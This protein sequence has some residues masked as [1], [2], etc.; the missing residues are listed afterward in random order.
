MKFVSYKLN[1]KLKNSIYLNAMSESA[2]SR[3]WRGYV[4]ACSRAWRVY[5]LTCLRACLT[6]LRA[7]RARVLSVLLYSH[8]SLTWRT[9]LALAYSCFCL[10]IYFVYINQDFAIKTKLLIYVDLS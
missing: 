2:K 7:W 5:M 1:K 9:H 10:I 3:A 8:A 4:L 6:C